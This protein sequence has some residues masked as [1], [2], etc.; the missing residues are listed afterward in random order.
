[1]MAGVGVPSPE[2]HPIFL[3]EYSSGVKVASLEYSSRVYQSTLQ[4][5]SGVK[6]ASLE[7]SSRV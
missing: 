4:F 2:R 3:L 1:M 5:S 7:Y 6:V